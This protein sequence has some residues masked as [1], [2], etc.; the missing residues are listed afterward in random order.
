MKW[1]QLCGSLNILWHGLSLE[2]EWKLTF[3]SLVATA[4]FSSFAGSTFTAS[5]FRIWNS[6]TGIPSPPLA[7]LILILPKAHLTTQSRMS[8]SRSVPTPSWL[9]WSLRSFLD[10]SSVYSCY[11][12]S[13]CLPLL[14]LL[15]PCYFCPLLYLSLNE[16][17]P[18]YLS[19]FDKISILSHS[20][21]FLYFFALFT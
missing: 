8:G 9:S 17:F 19:F 11:I 13:I 1:I 20:I 4:E 2:L 10:S 5:W 12:F 7:L 18:W 3:S 16:M 21:V 6:S 14:H 15:G